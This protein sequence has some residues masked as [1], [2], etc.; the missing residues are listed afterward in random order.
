MD[1]SKFRT[2]FKFWKWGKYLITILVFVFI[3][4]FVGDHSYLQKQRR[5]KEI[6][7]YEQQTMRYIQLYNEADQTIQMLN[8]HDNLERYAREQYLMHEVNE[9]IYLVNSVE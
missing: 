1:F 3:Y 6:S 9:D 5:Q 2:Y 4:L 7:E 8:D